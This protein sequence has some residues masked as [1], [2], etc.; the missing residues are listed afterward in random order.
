MP[1]AALLLAVA[2][3]GARPP[4]LT[5][6]DPSAY[7]AKLEEAARALAAQAQGA[8]CPTAT[9]TSVKG[10]PVDAAGLQRDG[11]RSDGVTAA[12]NE[13]LRV[14]G[15]GRETVVKLYIAR[16]GDGFGLI[17]LSPGTG[18]AGH[19]LT[20]DAL[21]GAV[22]ALA[23][24]RPPPPCDAAEQARTLRLADTALTSPY[25]PGR[26]WSERWTFDVCGQS[27]AV[28]LAFTPAADGGT[29]W[30]IKAR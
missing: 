24:Q 30:S 8:P 5:G 15:C 4:A 16:R 17:P 6:P 21:P 2:G 23:L 28:D 7:A 9:V 26:P 22:S 12:S 19:R 27:R 20:H 25:A 14:T 1:V 29:D 18:A 13:V 10:A 3:L 11:I